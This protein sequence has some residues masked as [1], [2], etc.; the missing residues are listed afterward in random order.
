MDKR[1]TES[2]AGGTDGLF[3]PTALNLAEQVTEYLSAVS[4]SLF[5]PIL[6]SGHQLFCPLQVNTDQ[7]A[8]ALFH[9]RH[10]E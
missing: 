5:R 9:H 2:P 4:A 3:R 8:D 10:P 1:C 6:S 7:L